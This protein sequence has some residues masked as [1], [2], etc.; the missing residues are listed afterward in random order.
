MLDGDDAVRAT[1]VVEILL[2]N[3]LRGALTGGLAIEAQLRAHGRPVLRRRLND[4]DFVVESFASIPVSLADVFLQHHVH[5]DADE[6][7]ILL[8]LV[9]RERAI[10][11]DLFGPFGRTLSRVA[12]L[13]GDTGTLDVVSVEDLVARSTSFVCGRLQ[14][15]RTI[16]RKHAMAFWRL[17]GLGTPRLLAEAWEDHRQAVAGTLEELPP[18]RR[19]C[20]SGI[21]S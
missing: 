21:P 6:G 9:D 14:Q 19:D 11:I 18:R 2:H 12:R 17:R 16:D 15:G 8:Q 7:K 13:D 10:R 20:S 3:G 5:P 1:R 4:L